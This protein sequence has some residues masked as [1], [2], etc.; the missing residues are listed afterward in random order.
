MRS[1][2]NTFPPQPWLKWTAQG[3]WARALGP[4]TRVSES[5]E[6]GG[7]VGLRWVTAVTSFKKNPLVDFIKI[8]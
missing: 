3:E 5:L 4:P 6:L 8:L 7:R 2:L 1:D